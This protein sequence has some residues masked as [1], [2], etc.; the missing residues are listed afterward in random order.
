MENMINSKENNKSKHFQLVFLTIL[1]LFGVLLTGCTGKK[2]GEE[3]KR[4]TIVKKKTMIVGKDI[5]E[6][7]FNEFFYTY[8]TTTYPPE[9]QRYRFYMEDGEYMFYHEKREGDS[10]FLTEDDI[11]VNGSMKL[12]EEEWQIFWDYMKKGTVKKRTS[13]DASGGKGPW[14]YLYW[15]GD[16]EIIQEF[17][18]DEYDTVLDFEQFC[19]DLKNKQ[20]GL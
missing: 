20:M 7:D 11:T 1:I 9:F 4:D 3:E 5:I 18:F 8:A 12:S 14:L 13:S 10:V 19:I 15:D 17:S 2:D 6:N 16:E